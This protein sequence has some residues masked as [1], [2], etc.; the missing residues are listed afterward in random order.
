MQNDN[1]GSVSEA[2]LAAMNSQ[3][4][5]SEPEDTAHAFIYLVSD[6]ARFVTAASIDHDGAIRLRY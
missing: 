4:V 6:E 1:V 3:G 2:A 5:A